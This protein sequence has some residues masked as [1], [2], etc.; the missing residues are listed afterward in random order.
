MGSGGAQIRLGFTTGFDELKQS[1]A[2]V[3][4]KLVDI[5]GTW[6]LQPL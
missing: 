3:G 4:M 2:V 5:R 1:L 6:V